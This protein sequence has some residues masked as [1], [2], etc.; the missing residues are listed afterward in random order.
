[1]A[2][3]SFSDYMIHGVLEAMKV[4]TAPRK[5]PDLH[6]MG[7]CVGGILTLCLLGYLAKVKAPVNVVSATLLRL[8]FTFHKLET[9]ESF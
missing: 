8:S 3:H 4:I 2:G 5:S 9:C 7:Y 6:L 1:M